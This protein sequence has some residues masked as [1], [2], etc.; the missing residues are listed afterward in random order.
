MAQQS[1]KLT[2]VKYTALDFSTFEDELLA[3]LQA[4]FGS[5]FND[6]AV[7]DLGMVLEDLVSFAGDTL[8]FYIDR[9]ATDY[10]FPTART[11]SAISLLARQA[12]YKPAPASAAN[13]DIV[14]QLLKSYPFPITYPAGFQFQGPDSTTWELAADLSFEADS[15]NTPVKGSVYEGASI[16]E[17]FVGTGEVGQTFPLARLP[18]GK[19]VVSGSVKVTVDGVPFPEVPFL[20][21]TSDPQCEVGY[22]SDTPVIRFGD[23][24]QGYIPPQG[25]E[26]V[27]TYVATSGVSGKA[28][29]DTIQTPVTPLLVA[30]QTISATF[31]NPEASSGG[32]DPESPEEVRANAPG[33]A[34]AHDKCITAEDYVAVA[35]AFA[36]PVA[37]RVAVA[38]AF[39]PREAASDS[40]FTER[41][42]IAHDAAM[43]P[44]TVITAQKDIATA[45]LSLTAGS[46]KKLIDALAALE[47]A[48]TA[49]SAILDAVNGAG[50]T[51]GQIDNLTAAV[52]SVKQAQSSTTQAVNILTDMIPI[53]AG[54]WNGLTVDGAVTAHHI[55]P[56][57]VTTL[58]NLLKQ[59]KAQSESAATQLGDAGP[60]AGPLGNAAAQAVGIGTHA[61]A[62]YLPSGPSGA[63]VDVGTDVAAAQVFEDTARAA[64]VII[65]DT[66]TAGR[67]AI[68]DALQDVYDYVDTILAVDGKA[69]VVNVPILSRDSDGFYVAPATSLILALQ[70][71]LDT[72]KEVTHTV[73]VVDGSDAL[74]P[75]VL[76]YQIGILKGYKSAVVMGSCL[77]A[78]ETLLKNRPFHDTLYRDDVARVLEATAGV[79]WTNVNLSGVLTPG[80]TV[81]ASVLDAEGNLPAGP[82]HIIT[83]GRTDTSFIEG[84]EP[85]RRP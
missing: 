50:P 37:G 29:K 16:S 24:A 3:E 60:V 45:A 17:T 14:G 26:I 8:G 5:T 68:A 83:R 47:L 28:S 39:S 15:V 2:K 21:W 12:G 76:Q 49:I 69:N 11:A 34:K 53:N 51:Q 27:V 33:V 70:A 57:D 54:V 43:I 81:D 65:G 41:Y 74:M 80:D 79:A 31:T 56:D 42:T 7:S 32:D 23:G 20:K 6:F 85:R 63:L 59:A 64:V 62:A 10:Y 84:Q 9:R 52:Q 75:V 72:K 77:K 25:V 67:D 78:V 71:S 73:F 82:G 22:D 30:G 58:Q 38:Q 4:K 44:S 13:A 35:G 1:D 19:F 36:D 66:N 61:T 48:K 46:G 40:V 55:H 18:A